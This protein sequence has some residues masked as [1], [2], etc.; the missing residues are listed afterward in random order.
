MRKVEVVPYQEAWIEEFEAEAA[1]IQKALGNEPIDIHHIGSTSV[2]G[3]CAKPIIDVMPVVANIS[4]IVHYNEAMEALGYTP[5]GDHGIDERRFFLKGEDTRTH[6]VHVFEK[7]SLHAERHLAFR[8]Y[9]I[10]HREVAAAYGKLK[11]VLAETCAGDVDAYIEG[12]NGWILKTE[13][14]AIRWYREER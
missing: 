4:R 7:D 3:L 5:M 12:K 14:E 13:R 6:H 10:A 2:P 8:D 11:R 1:R 9:L